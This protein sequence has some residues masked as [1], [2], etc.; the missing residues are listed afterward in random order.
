M[1]IFISQEIDN[2][3]SEITSRIFISVK[4][5]GLSIILLYVSLTDIISSTSSEEQQYDPNTC[6]CPHPQS[7][8]SKH[9][10]ATDSALRALILEKNIEYF[11]NYLK[12]GG[13]YRYPGT[14]IQ[15][16]SIILSKS[17]RLQ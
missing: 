7:H 3:L 4:G 5:L 12:D 10:Y 14:Y 2:I 16:I 13:I 9:L 11:Q 17:Y 1:I 6:Y 15:E 8:I